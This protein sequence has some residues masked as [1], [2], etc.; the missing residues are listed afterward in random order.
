[1]KSQAAFK[2]FKPKSMAV[3]VNQNYE[4]ISGFR[5]KNLALR[6]LATIKITPYWYMA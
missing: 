5:M 2:I 4:A 1:M 3:L 6:I